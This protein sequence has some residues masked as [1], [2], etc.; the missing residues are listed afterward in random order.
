MTKNNIVTLHNAFSILSISNNPTF[1][2]DNTQKIIVQ[3]SKLAEAVANSKQKRLHQRD[4]CKH[5]KNTPGRLRES[6]D[7]FFDES[8]TQA[9]DERTAMAM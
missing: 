9:E 6:N 1:E 2:S 7:L 3:L 4:Q 8:I 5:V